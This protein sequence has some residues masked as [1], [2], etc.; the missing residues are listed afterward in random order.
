MRSW[1][2]AGLLFATLFAAMLYTLIAA[3]DWDMAT[4][5]GAIVA[6]YA[7]ALHLAIRFVRRGARRIAA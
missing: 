3:N 5:I 6:G 7:A 1:M 4:V 2:L